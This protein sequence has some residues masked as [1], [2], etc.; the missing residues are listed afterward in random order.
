M[1]ASH[2]PCRAWSA[3]SAAN[4]SRALK[5]K[6]TAPSGW[7]QA[8]RRRTSEARRAMRCVAL[9]LGG[10]GGDLLDVSRRGRPG[11]ARTVRTG[12]S[13]ARRASARCGRSLRRG[14]RPRRA[15]ARR[16]LRARPRVAR[17]VHRTGPRRAAARRRPRSR[18]SRRCSAAAQR[19]RW[20]RRRRR[21]ARRATRRARSRTRRDWATGPDSVTSAEPGWLG[22]PSWRNH[23]AP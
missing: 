9:R 22:V 4:V 18:R 16:R 11:R 10:A 2:G 7:P 17:D 23:C 1:H 19:A 8:P 13:S 3:N 20:C 15:A 12:R 14:R 6:L 21:S 5:M